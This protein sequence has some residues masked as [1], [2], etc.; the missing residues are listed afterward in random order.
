[1]TI[2]PHDATVLRF[3]NRHL[4]QNQNGNRQAIGQIANVLQIPASYITFVGEFTPQT[5][6]LKVLR[7]TLKH[8][9]GFHDFYDI[10][11]TFLCQAKHNPSSQTDGS[12][13]AWN[14]DRSLIENAPTLCACTALVEYHDHHQNASSISHTFA[15]L[16]QGAQQPR[17]DVGP[18]NSYAEFYQTLVQVGTSLIESSG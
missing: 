2:D 7:F 13:I 9:D 6:G 16:H 5:L 4:R 14:P 12:N 11:S 10:F 8:L 18:M 1:M 17:I 15:P 3:V